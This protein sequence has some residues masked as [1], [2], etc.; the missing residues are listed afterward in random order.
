MAKQ[1][2]V[3]K[4]KKLHPEAILPK[5][6]FFSDAGLDLFTYQNVT[7]AKNS[8]IL[9][10]VGFAVE[11]PVGYEIQIRS[12]SGNALKHGITVLNSPGTIDQQYRGE[13]GVIL[14]NSSDEDITFEAGKAVAQMVVSK[15][16]LFDFE[17]TEDL[18]DTD[19]GVGGFGHTG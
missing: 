19:R 16:E 7:I 8:R 6:A 15:V 17:L 4:V 3:F 1:E 18:S 11:I 12:R 13:I 5:R 2:M 14:Y 9:V 10:K